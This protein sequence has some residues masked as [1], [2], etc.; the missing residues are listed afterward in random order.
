MRRLV[1]ALCWMASLSWL[2][3]CGR[4][5]TAEECQEIVE[6]M[7]RLQAASSYPARPDRIAE[8]IKKAKSDPVLRERAAKECVGHPIT[9]QALTC[10][11]QAKTSQ[12]VLGTCLR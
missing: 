6:H 2:P 8:E 4:P 5:A 1:P 11:R 12:E 9:E 3:G 10:I 7:A